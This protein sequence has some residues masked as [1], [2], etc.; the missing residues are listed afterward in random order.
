MNEVSP[1]VAPPQLLSINSVCKTLDC[2]RSLVYSLIRNGK[3]QC[4][5]L[6]ADKRIPASEV[7]RIATHG[8]P[9]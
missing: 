5:Q 8:L 2:S 1:P 4:V 9:K 7:A 3:L 6:G